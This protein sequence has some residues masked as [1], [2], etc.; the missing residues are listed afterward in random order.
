MN[1]KIIFFVFFA[2]ILNAC[3]QQNDNKS[4]NYSFEEKYKNS[5]FALIYNDQL[6]KEKRIS[7]KI[8]DRSLLIYH[9]TLK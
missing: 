2:I 3:N 5:G 1:Y 4:V 6:K 7:R 8:D 9:K